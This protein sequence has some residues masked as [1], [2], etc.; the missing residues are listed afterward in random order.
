MNKVNSLPSAPNI[1]LPQPGAEVTNKVRFSGTTEN[2]KKG[3]VTVYRDLSTIILF[4]ADVTDDRWEG[5]LVE[6]L[7][8]GS[9]S[10]VATTKVNGQE[11][12]R[13]SPRMFTVK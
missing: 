6:D 10:V 1:V 4:Q 11:S 8:K 12:H 9:I 3:V 13:S 7:P 5:V 2:V